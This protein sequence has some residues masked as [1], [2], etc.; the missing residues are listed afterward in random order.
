VNCFTR[1]ASPGR[2]RSAREVS[3]AATRV[4]DIGVSSSEGVGI[5]AAERDGNDPSNGLLTFGA[6]YG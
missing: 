1:G 2:W 5:V 6:E 3:S 4:A